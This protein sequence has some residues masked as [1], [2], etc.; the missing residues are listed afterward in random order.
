[1]T[2]SN[3]REY[4]SPSCWIVPHAAQLFWAGRASS[5]APMTHYGILDAK[6]GSLAGLFFEVFNSIRMNKANKAQIAKDCG[7]SNFIQTRFSHRT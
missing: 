4:N 5:G 2:A 7:V 6:P 1:M 3:A